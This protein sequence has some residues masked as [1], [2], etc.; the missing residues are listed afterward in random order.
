M[1]IEAESFYI[2]MNVALGLACL[3]SIFFAFKFLP[4]KG[5]RRM[6]I[7][8]LVLL[9]VSGASLSFCQHILRLESL[10]A[11]GDSLGATEG[12]VEAIGMFNYV[13]DAANIL[14]VV[15][16]ALCAFVAKK[17]VSLHPGAQAGQQPEGGAE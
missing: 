13:A 15:A 12:A 3:V 6:L 7:T 14:E 17:L 11:M 2:A 4:A 1:R 8:A 5:A 9:I 10:A 16:I